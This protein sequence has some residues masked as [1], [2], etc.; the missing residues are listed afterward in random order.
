MAFDYAR[1]MCEDSYMHDL[2]EFLK[3]SQAR[4]S[5]LCPR[6]VLGVRVALAGMKLLDMDP[7]IQRR[8]KTLMVV[9]ETDGCFVDGIEVTA[10]VSVGHRS[11]KIE[12]FGKIAATFVDLKTSRAVRLHPVIGV[13]KLA[14]DY[15]PLEKRAYFAQLKAYQIIPDDEL[16]GIEWVTLDRDLQ[17]ITG[18]P[19]QRACC[20]NC[21]EEIINGR[22]VI[23]NDATLCMACAGQAYYYLETET[24]CIENSAEQITV[25]SPPV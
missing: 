25:L 7:S 2:L 4:H 17:Q 8:K 23:E 22:E 24:G 3:A 9:S 19:G 15:F 20:M 1:T 13:R 6:Q 12:D 14:M 18:T 21:G 11:L 10:Q 5:H 16:L